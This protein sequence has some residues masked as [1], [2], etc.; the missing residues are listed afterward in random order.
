M[1]SVPILEDPDSQIRHEL[2]SNERLLWTGRPR[3]GLLLRSSDAIFIPFSLMW[4]GFAIFW[5]VSVIVAGAP[6]F[7]VLW[8]IP[9]VLVGLYLIFG[10]FWVD[11]RERA[12]AYYGVTN[13]RVLIISGLFRRTVKSLNI[14][15]LTDVSL[16]EKGD[17]SGTIALGPTNPWQNW[18]SDAVWPSTGRWSPPQLE[19]ID[20]ARRV[21]EII[22]DAQQAAKKSNL[23]AV[24]THQSAE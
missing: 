9:F 11:A 8:G 7:F 20:D 21:Y 12:K 6:V 19:L 15:T 4:G 10:R 18:Y 23:Q 16:I 5:E 24:A 1:A 2:G 14:D 13:E 17:G 3:L 22:R